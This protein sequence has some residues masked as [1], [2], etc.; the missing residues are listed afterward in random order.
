MFFTKVGHTERQIAEQLGCSKIAMYQAIVK[1]KELGTNTD[2]KLSGRPRKASPRTD[3]LI[4]RKVIN[5]PTCSAEK[6][7][8]DLNETGISI[9]R[10]TIIRRLVEEFG[11]KSRKPARKPRAT[12]KM[13]KKHLQ[14]ALQHKDWTCAQ[15][16]KVLFLNKFTVQQFAARKRNVRRPSGTRYNKKYT[17]ETVKHPPSVTME[18]AN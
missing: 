3:I 7:R 18:G 2:A 11:L 6:I 8:A 12:L 17:Q 16:S 15:W 1:L 14:L 5:S 9:S 10:Q 4:K 13:K